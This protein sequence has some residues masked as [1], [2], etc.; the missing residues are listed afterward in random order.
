MEN[1][2]IPDVNVVVLDFKTCR[3]KEMVIPNEDGTY[4][5]LINSRLSHESRLET[6]K[7][8]MHHINSNDFKK[9]MFN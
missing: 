7:H 2:T 5:I 3:G 4:T 6:Y 9:K 1:M 8:A